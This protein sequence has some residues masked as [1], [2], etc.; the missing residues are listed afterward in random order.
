MKQIIKIGQVVDDGQGDYLRRGGQKTNDNFDELYTE[1]GDGNIPHSAGAWKTKDNSKT[2]EAIFGQSI[3]VNTTKGSV[4]VNLPKGTVNDYNKVVRLRD[5]WN[6]WGQNPVSIFPAA[7]ATIKGKGGEVQLSTNY[8]DVELVYCAPNR[9]E[10]VSN[11]RVDKITTSDLST[12]AKREYIATQGQTD[13]PD[14]FGV[15]LYNIKNTEVYLRGNL[16]YYGQ[17]L[18][19]DSNYGSIGVGGDVVAID[20]KSIK[21][22]IPCNAGDPVTIITYMDGIASWRSTYNKHVIEVLDSAYTDK[23]SEDGS[24]VVADLKTKKRFT[25]A[26]FGV[27]RLEKVNPNSVELYINGIEQ[28]RSGD[29]NTPMFYCEGGVG[30]TESECES[31]GGVWSVAGEDFGVEF[32]SDDHVTGFVINTPLTH[33]DTLTIKWYNNDIGTLMEWDN[34]NGI[35]EHT[36]RIYLNNEYEFQLRDKIEYSD[37]SNPSQKTVVHLPDPV[38]ARALDVFDFFDLCYPIGT[39]YKNAHNAA[40]PA[41]YMGMGT[42]TRYAEGRTI[43][44]W[45]SDPS[46]ST[47]G[48]NNNDLDS[49]GNPTHTAGGTVGS[50][51]ADL[52][53]ANIP[54][55]ETSDIVLVKDDNG[56]IVVGGCMIDPDSQGP[57]YTKYRESKVT[58][59]TGIKNPVDVNIIQPSITSYVWIRVA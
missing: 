1:L 49:S 44:G 23:V 14:V 18:T 50:K 5:V 55:L 10:F 19:A 35:K 36:D 32:G 39:I 27:S 59:N 11:K 6:T 37:Y 30:E 29:A 53:V 9:W 33:K 28:V 52:N 12:V 15:N 43:V 48:T 26:E 22:R 8:M 24:F 51:F 2:I 54:E 34:D 57:G 17:G 31:A 7:G 4:N 13:F 46:D 21:L 20:G 40:N 25:T 41:S 16:L 45:N 3:A 42:W 38:Q 56:N 58:V 47:F